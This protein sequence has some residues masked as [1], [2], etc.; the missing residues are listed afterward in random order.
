MVNKIKRIFI[1]HGFLLAFP[2]MVFAY[3]QLEFVNTDG[4]VGGEKWF[5]VQAGDIPYYIDSQTSLSFIQAIDNAHATWE[6][7]S[8]IV[9]TNA[10]SIN[11]PLVN[12]NDN[13][14]THSFA[15]TNA[16]FGR[17]VLAFAPTRVDTTTGEILEADVYYNPR[18]RWDTSGNP[19]G[20]KVDVQ[21]VAFHEVGHFHG[22]SHSAITDATMFR[23]IQPGTES[24]SPEEDDQI[25]PA[26]IYPDLGGGI[27]TGSISG[28]IIKGNDPVDGIVGG[29]VFA[30]PA[31]EEPETFDQAFA[32]DYSGN[33]QG[34]TP[35][36]NTTGALS[37]QYKIEG[38]PNGDYF[39]FLV[40]TNDGLINANQ[41][42]AYLADHAERGFPREFYNGVDDESND[43]ADR[44]ARVPVNVT[45]GDTGGIDFFT[46]TE[47]APAPAPIVDAA[48]PA[49]G[50]VNTRSLPVV[51][52]GQ[53]FVIGATVSFSGKHISVRSVSFVSASEL[54][55]NIRIGRRAE[56]GLRDVTVTNPD[57][58]SGTGENIFSVTP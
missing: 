33:V 36:A 7:F 34:E 49:S 32:H 16:F 40:P 1:I 39:V 11:A 8:A 58:Q 18:I 57:G 35:D 19:K 9:F 47:A 44:F 48:D 14:N 4:N 28:R 46:E 50:A 22:L 52:Q 38:L 26:L 31:A 6:P 51:I 55:I 13:Q 25:S 43:E 20:N 45:T 27:P 2:A 30:F 56:P 10:G 23:S 15:A 54:A 12:L 21:S 42:S 24:R 53:N 29:I 5:N 41:I 3:G 17:S 37:G